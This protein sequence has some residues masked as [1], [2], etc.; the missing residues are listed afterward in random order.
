MTLRRST[1]DQTPMMLFFAFSA[2]DRNLHAERVDSVA[3]EEVLAA[4]HVA[5]ALA[6]CDEIEDRADVA[7]E[8]IVAL[9]CERLATA[10][11]GDDAL[12]GERAVVRGRARP[13]VVGRGRPA[14]DDTLLATG[15]PRDRERLGGVTEEEGAGLRAELEPVRDVRTRVPIGVDLQVVT[16][17]R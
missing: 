6:N 9:P 5:R 14:G 16:R 4:A 17:V 12:R 2:G 15:D 1:D 8:R 7:E 11:E 13:D 10:G 3:G